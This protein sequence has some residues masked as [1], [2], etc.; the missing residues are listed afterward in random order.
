MKL[1]IDSFLYAPTKQS[2]RSKTLEGLNVG[3]RV[4]EQKIGFTEFFAHLWISVNVQVC[5]FCLCK[6]YWFCSSKIFS[7]HF[8]ACRGISLH[9]FFYWSLATQPLALIQGYQWK[10]N[11]K[12]YL[13]PLWC[14]HYSKFAK[15]IF[16]LI[17]GSLIWS[18]HLWALI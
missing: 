10:D 5:Q 12:N 13:N 6:I 15:T 11:P 2:W 16:S 4:I 18:H 1:M 3:S 14:I 8:F 7:G 17:W 9:H